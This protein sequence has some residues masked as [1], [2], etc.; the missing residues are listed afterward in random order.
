MTF[1]KRKLDLTGSLWED[2]IVRRPR[3]AEHKQNI[4]LTEVIHILEEFLNFT[5]ESGDVKDKKFQ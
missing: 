2:C 1:S 5:F 4:S 3:V